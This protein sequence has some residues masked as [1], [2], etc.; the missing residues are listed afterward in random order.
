MAYE[1]MGGEEYGGYSPV[2]DQGGGGG[3]GGGEGMWNE[4]AE[5]A[6]N[7]QPTPPVRPKP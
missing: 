2:P 1:D 3:G 6:M 4:A 5:A 7:G